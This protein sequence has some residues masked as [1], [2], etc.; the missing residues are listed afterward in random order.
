MSIKA[1]KG[2][3]DERT[4]PDLTLQN[5]LDTA[6]AMEISQL[7][8]SGRKEQKESDFILK[9]YKNEHSFKICH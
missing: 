5:I 3:S 4:E 1:N 8:A 6:R 9:C 7:Q 2:K